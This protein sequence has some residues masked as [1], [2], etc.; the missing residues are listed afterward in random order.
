MVRPMVAVVLVG[1]FLG[2]GMP[3]ESAATRSAKDALRPFNDLIGTWKGTGTAVGSREFQQKNF[4]VETMTWEWHFK[5]GDAWLTVAF[6]KSKHFSKGELRYEPVK[7][8]YALTLVTSAKDKV[9][10]T[11]KLKDKVLTLQRDADKE[12]QRLVF[13]FLHSNRFLY[14][15]ES[16]PEGKSLFARLYQVGATKEGVPF[17]GDDGRPECIITGGL[18]TIAV[19]HQGKTYYVCCSGCRDEFREHPEMYIKEYEAKK[20]KKGQ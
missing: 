7:D 6:D 18:G 13:T 8:E 19:M 15:A 12:S 14:R 17:A 20:A 11:G 3:A 16:K 1:L 5:A 10:F 2:R 4:W 9:T